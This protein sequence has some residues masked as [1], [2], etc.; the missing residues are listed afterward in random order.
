MKTKR[1]TI[2]VEF[3]AIVNAHVNPADVYCDIE[4]V[5]VKPRADGKRVGHVIEFTTTDV[6]ET[7]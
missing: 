5:H 3:T 1:V 6:A 2:L 7:E 4:L